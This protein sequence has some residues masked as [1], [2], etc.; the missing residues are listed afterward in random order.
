MNAA[1]SVRRRP[2]RVAVVGGGIA[3]MVFA[4]RSAEFGCDVVLL[5]QGEDA[6]YRCNSRFTGG[7][8][9]ICFHDI[10]EPAPELAAVIR[11]TTAG[12]A[13]DALVDAVAEDAR[14]AVRWLGGKGVRLMKAGPDAWRQ[15]ILAPPHFM[16][17]G[18]NW[19]GRGGDVLLRTLR[20]HLI[21][22]G[23]RILLGARA[24]GLVMDG[25]R[26]AGVEYVRAGQVGRLETDVVMLADGG[27]QANLDMLKQYVSPAPERLKQR[28]AGVSRGDAIAL[29]AEAGA[30]LSGMESIY[31][32]LLCQ[33]ALHNERLW[34]YPIIDSVAGAAIVVDRSGR[35][36]MDEGLGGVYMTNCLA[37]LPDPQATVVVFDRAVWEGPATEFILPANPNL[38]LSGGAIESADSLRDLAMRMGVDPFGL[39]RTIADYNEALALGTASALTPPRTAANALA[40]QHPPF[41]AVR[42]V[43]GITFTMGGIVID[44]HGRVLRESGDAITGLYASGC[45]TGGLEGGVRSGYVGGLAKSAT[46]SWR[47][48]AFVAQHAY[49]N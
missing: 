16:K 43:P 13:V 15:H 24:V 31:G 36:V 33:D 4:V 30:A 10:D 18:L 39:E 42:L 45:C 3:G 32:H 12:F 34:P 20:A 23:G 19:Q 46:I 9:H 11:A 1:A 41:H 7:A 37:R 21:A 14:S 44:A 22:D 8:F 26:C 29:A 17:A 35:R 47:A 25:V 5:E 6:L 28:G 2:L 40:I 48:A 49:E 27:F 38:A